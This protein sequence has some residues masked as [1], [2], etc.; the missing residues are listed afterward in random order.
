MLVAVLAVAPAAG[1]GGFVRAKPLEPAASYVAR[2]PVKVWCAKTDTAW[3]T[4][5]TA[6]YDTVETHGWTAQAGANQTYID[7]DACLILLDVKTETLARIGA[8]AEILTHESIHMRGEANEGITDCDAMH[9]TP[10][11][12]VRFFGIKAG[13][14]LRSLMAQLWVWHRKSPPAYVAVC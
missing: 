1:A 5:L 7:S 11:V 8:A 6:R 2:K 3:R 9:E 4:F 10:G 12:V 13:K 14:Q